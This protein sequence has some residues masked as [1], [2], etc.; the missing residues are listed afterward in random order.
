MRRIGCYCVPIII[1]VFCNTALF[2]NL[3]PETFEDK[4]ILGS[5]IFY[6]TVLGKLW[7][8]KLIPNHW[9][10]VP[11]WGLLILETLFALLMVEFAMYL[12]WLPV[13]NMIDD[14]V[15]QILMIGDVRA[16][17][18]RFCAEIC[19]AAV[20][21]A[22]MILVVKN[23]IGH[24]NI[25]KIFSEL[26]ASPPSRKRPTPLNGHL[27]TRPLLKDN[28]LDSSLSWLFQLEEQSN[29]ACTALGIPHKFVT[30]PGHIVLEDQSEAAVAYV[31]A[32]PVFVPEGDG[33][34]LF[35]LL[36]ILSLCNDSG[37]FAL[38]HHRIQKDSV[39]SVVIGGKKVNKT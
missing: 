35:T 17:I 38:V 21:M 30:E 10:S 13:E 7:H 6:F 14:V 26:L 9:K 31:L 18:R 28:A 15:N 39:A 8:R 12:L 37:I 19:T 5:I 32:G 34:N 36:F 1:N 23:T 2:V 33:S 3:D 22:I 11:S 20:A 16:T 29:A 24:F 27:V 25:Q 4:P